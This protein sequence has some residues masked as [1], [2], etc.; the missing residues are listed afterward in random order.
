M[1]ITSILPEQN[2]DISPWVIYCPCNAEGESELDEFFLTL[3]SNMKSDK[4]KMFALFKQVS[5]SGPLNLSDKITHQLDRGIREFRAGRIRVLW[6]FDDDKVVI[7]SHGMVKKTQ[8]MPKREIDRAK[9]CKDTY[10]EAKKAGSIN[11]IKGE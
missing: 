7:C 9:R 3:G 6:F 8:K 2:L 1:Y 10:D 5:E 11:I 4:T